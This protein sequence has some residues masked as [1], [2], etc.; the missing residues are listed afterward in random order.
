MVIFFE[1]SNVFNRQD[2]LVESWWLQTEIV[3]GVMVRV[4][5]QLTGKVH[6]VQVVEL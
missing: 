4:L 6:A 5:A 2:S 3:L 1:L